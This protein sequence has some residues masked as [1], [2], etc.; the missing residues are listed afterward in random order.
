M[1]PITA[2]AL[3]KDICVGA[4]AGITVTSVVTDSRAVTPGCVFVAIKGARAD[5]H[6]FAKGALE[7]GAVLV[8]ASREVDG[9]PRDRTVLVPDVLDAMIQMGANYRSGFSPLVIGVTG[10]V[11]KTG[12]KE[13]CAAVL[14]GFGDTLKTQGNQNNEIGLPN[15]LFGLTDDTRYAVVEMGMQRQGEIAKLARAAKPDVGI[16][17]RIGEAHIETAGSIEAVLAAKLE[18]AEGLPPGAPLVLNGD[19]PLQSCAPLP[20]GVRAVFTAIENEECD[21]RAVDIR[22][23]GTGQRFTIRDTQY[24]EHAAF[25]PA[26]G[27]HNVMN[28]LQAYTAATRLGLSAPGSAAGLAQYTPAER[29]Q[30]ISTVG[31]VTLLEDYY[32]AN[33]D[34]MRAALSTLVDLGDEKHRVAVLGDMLELGPAA[35]EAHRELGWEVAGAGVRLLV[36]VGPLAAIAAAE[37][38]KHGVQAVAMGSNAE[39]AGYLSQ[40]VQPGD[41]LLIKASRGM[42][43][44][45]IVQALP[46]AGK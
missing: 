6:E 19:D 33:P 36:T 45:E 29:R 14:A 9:V 31:G 24:G 43:F 44:E 22:R 28:A 3:F 13:F 5:G 41:T 1:K 25:I 20:A 23:E 40:H 12:T 17:T 7:N 42:K 38:G 32:N 27:Q 10:S 2:K 8:V 15:T 18:I 46:F 11:G 16:I 37:A 30:Q 35:E 39:A 21:V 34:S 26:L 4:P